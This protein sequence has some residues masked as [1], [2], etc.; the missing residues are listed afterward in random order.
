MTPL[1]PLAAIRPYLL[2]IKAGAIVLVLAIAFGGGWHFGGR[3]AEKDLADFKLETAQANVASQAAV[4]EKAWDLR[5]DVDE[6]AREL[7]DSLAEQT[8][9]NSALRADLAEA[10]R[11]G[12]LTK[13][14]PA[15]NCPTL[16]DGFVRLWNAA[17]MP[18]P[19]PSAGA[20]GRGREAV[21]D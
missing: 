13:K 20:A 19:D 1:D 2:L 3:E 17:A 11:R 16:G 21:R 14:D 9:T 18:G 8:R 15:S 12:T 6:A 7:A 10:L 5:N 4:F